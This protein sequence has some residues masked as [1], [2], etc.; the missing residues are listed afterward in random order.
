[1]SR[2]WRASDEVRDLIEE[3]NQISIEETEFLSS[4][5]DF[6]KFRQRIY[7]FFGRGWKSKMPGFDIGTKLIE[8]LGTRP[9]VVLHYKWGGLFLETADDVKLD[10]CELVDEGEFFGVLP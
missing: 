9:E 10:N 1:M 8:L 3:Y 5:S 4:V 7:R 6:W 2:F